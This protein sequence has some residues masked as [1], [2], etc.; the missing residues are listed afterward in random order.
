[1]LRSHVLGVAWLARALNS[2][3]FVLLSENAS[4]IGWW[5]AI[6][7]SEGRLVVG[8]WQRCIAMSE[9]RY[10]PWVVFPYKVVRR[11]YVPGTPGTGI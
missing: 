3:S 6:A 9:E 8:P 4:R 10:E 5:D 1:M 7:L 11:W 2:H